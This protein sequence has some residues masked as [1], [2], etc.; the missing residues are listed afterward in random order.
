MSNYHWQDGVGPIADRPKRTELAWLSS[1]P[2]LFGTNE[3]ID[4]CRATKIE[5]FICLNSE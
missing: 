5:P 3:F 4:Y 2:N 1:E